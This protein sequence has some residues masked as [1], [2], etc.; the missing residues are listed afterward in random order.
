LPPVGGG[1]CLLT[2]RAV[3]TDGVVGTVTAAVLVRPGTA[4]T[5]NPPRVFA[6]FDTGCAL[7]DASAP[8]DC[9][10][11]PP[12]ANHFLTGSVSQLDGHPCALTIDDSCLIEA[13]TDALA[14][15]SA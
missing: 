5:S 14:R 15:Q 13:L 8:A 2:V 4:A 6:S 10:V 3:S 9:S 11:F 1:L 7:G 12:D